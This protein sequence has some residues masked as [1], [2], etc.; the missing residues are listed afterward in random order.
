MA[1]SDSI[2]TE[3]SW[4]SDSGGRFSDSD[5]S[6]DESAME[7]KEEIGDLALPTP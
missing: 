4:D 5:H 2:P 7:E 1:N 6:S 3:M